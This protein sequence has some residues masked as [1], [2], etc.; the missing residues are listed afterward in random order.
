MKTIKPKIVNTLIAFPYVVSWVIIWMIALW[1]FLPAFYGEPR[2]MMNVVIY[3]FI[4][5]FVYIA[6]GFI[7]QKKALQNLEYRFTDEKIEFIDGFLNKQTKS[8]MFSKITDVRS[9]QSIMERYF[10]IW[11]VRISTAW[12]IWYEISL[13]NLEYYDKVYEYIQDKIK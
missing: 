5:I 6:G 9:D 12:S 11:T 3:T 7:L 4:W 8:V 2:A 1:L 10:E 13:K